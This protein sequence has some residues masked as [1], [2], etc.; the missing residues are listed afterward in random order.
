MAGQ[1]GLSILSGVECLAADSGASSASVSLSDGSAI[2][3]KLVVAADG[4]R[5]RLREQAGIAARVR[6][7]GQTGVVANFAVARPHHNA[8]FQWFREDGILALLPLPGKRV[9]MVWSAPDARAHELLAMD[10]AALALTVEDASCGMLGT[11]VVEGTPAGFP[12]RRM[13]ADRMTSARL[14]LIGDAAHNVH[15]LAGQGLNLGFGDA[16][17]LAGVLAA[18]G[19]EKDC[20]SANLSR[21][22]EI[23][24]AEDILAMEL[25]TD[26]LQ[27]LFSSPLPGMSRLRNAGLRIVDKFSSLKRILVKRAL[28]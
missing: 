26:G 11:L 24:R 5:S 21:R 7:Y 23:S 4:A 19:M 22:Y 14:A 20:G 3:A 17:S 13:H 8:A 28:G 10:A 2:D 18:R 25:V 1:A 12:L 9:S 15:P 27:R 6:D 16:Q